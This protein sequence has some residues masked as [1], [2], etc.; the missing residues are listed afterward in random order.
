MLAKYNLNVG[1]K[2][3][4]YNPDDGDGTHIAYENPTGIQDSN[5][6][7]ASIV[8]GNIQSTIEGIT[9]FS[10]SSNEY[11]GSI[12][13]GYVNNYLNYLKNTVGLS[14]ST[15][16]SL[17]TEDMINNIFSCTY[18]SGKGAHYTCSVTYSWLNSISYWTMVKYPGD[19]GDVGPNDAVLAIYDSETNKS[20]G[21]EGFTV[22]MSNYNE[23]IMYGV[24]PVIT[25]STSEI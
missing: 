15:T 4:N 13:E 1:E 3:T 8:N 2:I 24:R 17:V 18:F 11:V 5:M 16:A 14:D 23:S 19:G 9:A 12:V 20:L 6:K 22:L 10:T 25:I 21:Y 7:G